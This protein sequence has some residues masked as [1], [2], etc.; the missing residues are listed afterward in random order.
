MHRKHLLLENIQ[1]L[2]I[3]YYMHMFTSIYSYVFR[4]ESWNAAHLIISDLLTT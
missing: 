4:C 3:R 2:F 1:E